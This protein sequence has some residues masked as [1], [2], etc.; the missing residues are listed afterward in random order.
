MDEAGLRSRRRAG[1]RVAAIDG[2]TVRRLADK[3]NGISPHPYRRRVGERERAALGRGKTDDHSNDT[4]AIPALLKTL[5]IKRRVVTI[6]AM[7]RRKKT[8]R[9]VV[10][11]DADYVLAV[12]KNQPRL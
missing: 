10:K 12:K 2:K 1:R 4:I 9:Q 8:A 6:D 5:E 7:G 3:G 11:L